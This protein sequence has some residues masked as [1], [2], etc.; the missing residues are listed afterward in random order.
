M[1]EEML[2][3]N[4]LSNSM[5]VSAI[6]SSECYKNREIDPFWQRK[7][8]L[9]TPSSILPT[10]CPTL[11]L[12]PGAVTPFPSVIF[13]SHIT[14]VLPQISVI[15]PVCLQADIGSKWMSS[16]IFVGQSL[17]LNL[18]ST[19]IPY[20]PGQECQTNFAPRAAFGLQW[21][22]R[23][24]LNLFMFPYHQNWQDIVLYPLYSFHYC[25]Y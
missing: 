13:S 1:V 23:A 15:H 17:S 8:V 9:L 16:I 4:D 22:Q 6:S 19:P 24:A 21:G 2:G 18:K 7:P 11:G 12:L 14:A 10:C 3:R 20:L 25:E 5:S